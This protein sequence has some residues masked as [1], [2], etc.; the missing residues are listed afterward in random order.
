MGKK[1][2]KLTAFILAAAVLMSPIYVAAQASIKDMSEL[3]TTLREMYEGLDGQEIR[4]DGVIGTLIG[5]QIYFADSTGRFKVELDAG[6]DVRRSIEGCK[7]N[8]FQLE[9]STCNVVGMA[10]ISVDDGDD[11]AGDGF[12]IGLIL[13]QVDSFEKSKE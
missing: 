13:Y 1:C 10:E 8:M 3:D 12:E 4:I 5:D 2:L 7:V 9:K 6:R 11:N